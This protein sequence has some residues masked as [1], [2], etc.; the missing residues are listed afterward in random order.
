[1]ADKKDKKSASGG[2]PVGP[3]GATNVW[4]FLFLAGIIILILGF[5]LSYF[6]G[7]LDGGAFKNYAWIRSAYKT[8]LSIL[9]YL[10][11]ISFFASIGLVYLI[12]SNARKLSKLNKELRM[13]FS[14]P[15]SVVEGGSGGASEESSMASVVRTNTSNKRWERVLEHSDS[16]NPNDWKIAI[17]EADSILDEMVKSMGYHGNNLGERLK[18]IE[19]SDFNT[20]NNAW[21]AHK[22]RNAIAHEGANFQLNERETRR[23]IE[24][25]RAVFEEFKYI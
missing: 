18:A 11:I 24:L 15:R 21:E 3:L 7:F 23:V 20:L 12:F 5:F 19:P 17:I 14:P 6:F 9:P 8:F 22:V 4:E 13:Q 2:P 25:Y 10:K 1:M 16:D